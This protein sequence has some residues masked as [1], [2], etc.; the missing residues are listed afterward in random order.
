M[1]RSGL[2]VGLWL[3]SVAA[4]AWADEVITPILERKLD[5]AKLEA[6]APLTRTELVAKLREEGL[7][8]LVVPLRPR[9]AVDDAS[10]P[11]DRLENVDEDRDIVRVSDED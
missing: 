2:A 11:E 5:Q 8:V 3:F 1:E 10:A 6:V 7:R 4:G 9:E